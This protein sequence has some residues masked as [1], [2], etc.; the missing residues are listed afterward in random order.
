[1]FR[2][3]AGK[4]LSVITYH[5][6][7][8]ENLPGF[9]FDTG[10]ISATPDEF[11]RELDFF[12]RH[13]DVMSLTDLLACYD[14]I[15]RFPARPAVI[16]FDDG[17]IDNYEI[18]WPLLRERQMPACFFVTSRFLDGTLVP[19]WD[20]I[21][22]CIHGA[23]VSQMASPFE[24]DP[25][26]LLDPANKKV[27]IQRFL[28]QI[29]R[30]AGK[31]MDSYLAYLKEQTG[32]DLERTAIEPLFMTWAQAKEVAGKGIEIGGHT[33]THTILSG[34]EDPAELKAEVKGC[35]DDIVREIGKKPLAFA[36][37]VGSITA[38]SREADEEISNAG[39]QM[40]FSHIH[41]FATIETNK[42]IRIPRL[43]SDSGHDFDAF[44]LRMARVPSIPY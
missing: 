1:M 3:R 8:P 38:M 25:P 17:Y 32:A 2:S 31:G 42:R 16:T 6:I 43:K 4:H 14:D 29:K 18:A 36:Y 41:S 19:W 27:S 34:I 20:Q 26:Y 12:R 5:R 24:N 13:L 35:Y 30:V 15:R 40:S 37:P 7:L 33:R 28:R 9:K 23:T 10:V 21:A 11:G 22:F 39:F 44:R